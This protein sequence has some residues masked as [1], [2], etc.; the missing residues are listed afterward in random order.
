VEHERLTHVPRI[1]LLAEHNTREGFLSPATLEAVVAALPAHMQDATRFAY[2]SGWRKGEVTTLTWA[3]VDR[4]AG[5]ITLR[6]ELRYELFAFLS[7]HHFPFGPV[8]FTPSATP[9]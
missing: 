3:D 2:L 8:N 6:R 1:T 9:V 5:L 4:A 7:F